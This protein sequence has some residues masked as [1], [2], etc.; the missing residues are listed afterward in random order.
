MAPIPNFVFVLMHLFEGTDKICEMMKFPRPV[1]IE[2][3][4]TIIGIRGIGTMFALAPIYCL[5]FQNNLAE[6]S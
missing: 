4:C 5:W 1:L 3:N 6:I 2:S